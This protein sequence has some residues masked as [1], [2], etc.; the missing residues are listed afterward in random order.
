MESVRKKAIPDGKPNSPKKQ[1]SR[2]KIRLSSYKD[3]RSKLPKRHR[4]PSGYRMSPKQQ[5]FKRNQRIPR[6]DF[7]RINPM[8]NMPGTF[9]RRCSIT[10][11]VRHPMQPPMQPNRR[12]TRHR[13]PKTTQRVNHASSHHIFCLA[14]RPTNRT[15]YQTRSGQPHHGEGGDTGISALGRVV[16]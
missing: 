16:V 15:R 10:C 8:E 12:T 6:K 1:L 4:N 9:R 11:E 5:T 13:A 3:H 2:L 14:T 7:N